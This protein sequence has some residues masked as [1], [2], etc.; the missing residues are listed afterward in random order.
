MNYSEGNVGR[1]FVIRLEDGDKLPLTIEDFAAKKGVKR[2]MC[3]L[4]GGIDH[5]G[6]IVVGPKDRDAMPPEPMLFTLDGVHE[7]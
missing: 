1:I 6:N 7:V 3:M 2:G 5:C 4:V